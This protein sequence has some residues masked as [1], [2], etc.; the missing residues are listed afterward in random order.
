MDFKRTCPLCRNKLFYGMVNGIQCQNPECFFEGPKGMN[1]EDAW[2]NWT[3]MLDIISNNALTEA[4][5]RPVNIE[6]SHYVEATS[7]HNHSFFFDFSENGND[8][9]FFI[10][11]VSETLTIS[12][13]HWMEDIAPIAKERRIGAI[14]EFR[15]Y[16]CSVKDHVP[17]LLSTKSIVTEHVHVTKAIENKR[18]EQQD[19][20]LK[21]GLCVKCSYRIEGEAEKIGKVTA[22]PMIGCRLTKNPMAGNNC[23][24]T[25]GI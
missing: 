11:T 23:P 20:K 3:S 16:G 15:L 13:R 24:L 8:I 7:S 10:P 5:H 21:V 25:Q 19:P 2:K 6:F 9:L 17:G 1:E 4:G 18:K 14:K 22:I 12:V